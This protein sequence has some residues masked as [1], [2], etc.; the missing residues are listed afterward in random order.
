MV[1]IQRKCKMILSE[2]KNTILVDL[3]L[4]RNLN[5]M[6]IQGPDPKLV[7]E[8][9]L[10][11]DASCCAQKLHD[12][13]E[14]E[15]G[16]RA[17]FTRYAEN[18][19]QGGVISALFLNLYGLDAPA[20]RKDL[21]PLPRRAPIQATA[22]QRKDLFW[23]LYHTICV[24]TGG[25]LSPLI[26]AYNRCIDPQTVRGT[27]ERY[28]TILSSFAKE[29]C[30]HENT[31][32][33]DFDFSPYI[34]DLILAFSA[35][36]RSGSFEFTPEG[37]VLVALLLNLYEQNASALEKELNDIRRDSVKSRMLYAARP[38]SSRREDLLLILYHALFSYIGQDLSWLI[39]ACDRLEAMR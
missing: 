27:V 20:L 31:D 37:K 23:R 35:N 10:E 19:R 11:S 13:L 16:G 15:L 29:V 12:E 25:E 38:V 2:F 18:S 24:Y 17:H 7:L 34:Q 28:Q 14:A 5:S 32:H 36:G 33:K 39:A 3:K 4:T 22:A 9:L 1:L 21:Y 6:P 26:A 8:R 30:H